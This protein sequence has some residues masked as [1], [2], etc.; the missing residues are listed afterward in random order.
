MYQYICNKRINEKVHLG[1]KKVK[2]KVVRN[3]SGTHLA[4]I[5][6][7][8]LHVV[9]AVPPPLVVSRTFPR[10]KDGYQFISMLWAFD[11]FKL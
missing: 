3:N 11:G 9:K 1:H 2:S 7:K 6:P 10:G 8:L 5:P 4:R